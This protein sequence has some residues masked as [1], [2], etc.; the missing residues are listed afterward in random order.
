MATHVAPVIIEAAINGM[1]T[2]RTNPQVPRTSDEIASDALRSIEAGAAI[3]HTHNAELAVGPDRAAELYLES[4][5]PVLKAR[6]NAILYPTLGFGGTIEERV[7]HQ[8]ILAEKGV[9]AEAAE[10][11]DLPS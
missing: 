2:K 1:T 7:G 8:A 11:L 4:W 3:I 10:L 9:P 5:Q 6:P